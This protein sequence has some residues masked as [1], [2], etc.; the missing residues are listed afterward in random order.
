MCGVTDFGCKVGE[1]FQEQLRQ[2][3]MS[4]VE[5]AVN[6][7]GSIASAWVNIPLMPTLGEWVGGGVCE[8]APGGG[9][10]C[11]DPEWRDSE[12]LVWFSQNDILGWW[13]GRS[14]CWA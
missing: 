13:V 10:I 2:W 3:T 4:M 12:L 6:L 1:A 14:W 5:G 9:V 7:G 8:P 11:T